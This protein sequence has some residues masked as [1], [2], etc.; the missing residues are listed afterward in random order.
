MANKLELAEQCFDCTSVEAERRNI[1]SRVLGSE[2]SA[3]QLESLPHYTHEI[4]SL[5]G[6]KCLELAVNWVG[7]CMMWESNYQTL[8][9]H[10]SNGY[11]CAQ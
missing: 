5:P 2:V 9:T 11:A 6:Q 7:S 4:P 1:I 3:Q 8:H 10:D